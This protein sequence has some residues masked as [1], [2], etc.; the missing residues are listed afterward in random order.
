MGTYLRWSRAWGWAT[1]RASAHACAR[2]WAYPR[3]AA[4]DAQRRGHRATWRDG[5]AQHCV[6]KNGTDFGPEKRYR[7]CADRAECAPKNGSD[8]GT[9]KRYHARVEKA[10]ES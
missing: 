9:E 3:T 4:H 6:P 1:A 8:F 5:I 10:S 2:T 7:A